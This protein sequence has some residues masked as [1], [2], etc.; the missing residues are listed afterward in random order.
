MRTLNVGDGLCTSTPSMKWLRSVPN[1][2]TAT[3]ERRPRKQ[4]D[5]MAFGLIP[6]CLVPGLQVKLSGLPSVEWRDCN[7][8][9]KCHEGRVICCERVGTILVSG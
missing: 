2:Q 8:V 9:R 4:H 5:E 6:V 7:G 3:G 1:E